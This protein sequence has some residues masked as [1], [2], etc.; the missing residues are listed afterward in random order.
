MFRHRR[1]TSL[2]TASKPSD[3]VQPGATA[4]LDLGLATFLADARLVGG[5]CSCG[6]FGAHSCGVYHGED[7]AEC[8][9]FAE[10]CVVVKRISK[11]K[12]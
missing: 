8:C 10:E 3:L 12:R 6:I 5:P 11:P 2:D 1:H 4:G 7:V 9:V